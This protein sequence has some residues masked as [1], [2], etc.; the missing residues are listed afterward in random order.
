MKS[1]E[2]I[3]QFLETLDTMDKSGNRISGLIMSSPG[4]GKTT[5][6]EAWC[7]LKDYNLTTL[8]ASNFSSDDILGIEVRTE[9]KMERLMPSWFNELSEKAQNGKRNILFLDEIS[10]ADSYIQSPLFNL[11]FNYKLASR[12]LPENTLI[13]A[14]GNYSEEL[15]NAFKMTAPLVNRFLIL[16]LTNEDY[17]FSEILNGNGLRSIK[18]KDEMS[19]FIGIKE[20]R[21]KKWNFDK[22]KSWISENKPEFKFGKSEFIDDVEMGGL[23]GFLSLRS[24]TYSLQFAEAYMSK[25]NDEIWMRIVGDTMG[26]S[27]KREGK[28]IREILKMNKSFFFGSNGKSSTSEFSNKKISE[29]CDLLRKMPSLSGE[30]AN[31]ALD[32][33]EEKI[34]DADINKVTSNDLRSF[35]N[36]ASLYP[37]NSR[38][39]KMSEVLTSKLNC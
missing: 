3:G 28:P 29:I 13:V 17:S 24:L 30:E 12:N 8:I 7:R 36:L 35:T 11:I 22:L 25:Y 20:P 15:G 18:D 33:L 19:N 27:Q 23:L 9:N 38:I 21:T 2:Y 26:M 1:N 39:T 37:S 5:T 32:S 6:V 16:N 34:L 4:F 10:A 31:A 14:A